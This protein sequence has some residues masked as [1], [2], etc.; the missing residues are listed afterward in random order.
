LKSL[1]SK[2]AEK[3]FYF[4]EQLT[5]EETL[6]HTLEFV[7]GHQR[8]VNELGEE[9][10]LKELK[11]NPSSPIVPAKF[12]S[13]LPRDPSVGWIRL[14]LTKP[15]SREWVEAISIV[16]RVNAKLEDGMH[17]VVRGEKTA[18]KK[19]VEMFCQLQMLP[20]PRLK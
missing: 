9:T 15:I 3:G 19:A 11:E 12:V 10:Y 18:V 14:T 7:E 6:L 4:N 13:N 16:L 5:G 17:V 1:N 8:L 20:E 2:S